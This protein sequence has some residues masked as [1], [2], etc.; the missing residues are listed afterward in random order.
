MRE[1]SELF[2]KKLY[3]P[4]IV[5]EGFQTGGDEVFAIYQRADGSREE[6]S[7]SNLR[8]ESMALVEKL[9]AMGLKKG[10]R[11]ALV[12]AMKPWWYSIYHAA[13]TAGYI[14]VCIDPGA[15]MNQIQSMVQ[16]TECRCVF[17]G[18]DNFRLPRGLEGRIPVMDITPGFPLRG[19]CDRVDILLG[20]AAPMDER[21][22]FVI[23][24]SGTTG[25]RRKG[26]LLP[27]SSVA[28]ALEWNGSADSGIYKDI[29][30][31]TMH[32][33][34]LMLFPP[35][36]IA[37]LMAATLDI[38][39]NTQVIMLEKLTPQVLAGVLQEL[40]PDNV[41]TVP[42]MLTVLMKKIRATL[43]ESPLKNAYVKAA[44][45][46]SGFLRRKFGWKLGFHLL[47][48]VNRAALGGELRSFMIGAS[49]CDAE[50]MRF[51]LDMGIDVPLAYGLSELGAPLAVT[52]KG[53]YLNS[54]GP[55]NH[56]GEGM[57]IRI[58]NPDEQGRGEVEILSPFRMISY[59]REEDMEGCFTEDGYFKT[60]DLGYYNEENCLV[61]C[62][63]AKE[64]IVLR[65]GEK[66]L[67]EEIEAQYKNIPDLAELA[68]FKVPGSGGCDA[69]SLAGVVRKESGL[70]DE[71]I[72]LHI[73]ER[74]A[75]LP[76]MYRPQEV[77]MLRELPL[78][79][80]R[81]VQ[82]FRLTEM[83]EKG[84]NAPVTEASLRAVAEEGLAGELR[85]LLVQVGGPQ[86]KEVELT[87]GLLLDL[88]SLQ[89]I[90]LSVAVQEKFGIDLFQLPTPPETFGALLQAVSAFDEI[91]HTD[92]HELD[93]SRYPEPVSAV[94][95]VVV[96]P[97]VQAIRGA[98]NVH[99]VGTENIPT[100]GNFLICSNHITTLDPVWI[101]ACMPTRY[102]KNT[103][104]VGKSS[105]L[106]SRFLKDL[107]R[108]HN[109]IPVDRTGNSLATL[110]RC[111][112]LLD[113]GWNVEIFPEGTN[114]ENAKEL[115]SFKEGPARLAI[116]AGK[117]VLPVHIKGL[118]HVE[119]HH[120]LP[121]LGSRIEV[122]FGAPISPEGM[123]PA[124]FT[125][126]LRD[127]IQ[128]L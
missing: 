31:Y 33:R 84:L 78:S 10:D 111:K 5:E 102:R 103:A 66:L 58:V 19:E 59:L 108:T 119:T 48:S 117:P 97:L 74:A 36:H 38:Y 92:K 112:E 98:W 75:S 104:I 64:A 77:Y 120:F 67:P 73:L 13:L 118:K 46:L 3:L 80:T 11:I 96:A 9:E 53:Y 27:G 100:E 114:F 60:G 105:L 71:V 22:T 56:H 29:P 24:S 49:P 116:A 16:E 86:W 42:G 18:V 91:E 90:E 39:A 15:P 8:A 122:V 109:F 44:M 85:E 69:F 106:E 70:P 63:R 62:G 34:D 76:A 110:E 28:D 61:I 107:V 113:E 4:A 45:G 43:A 57:D 7:Y 55:V 21:G 88:D 1:N 95:R 25:E 50:T 124:A 82:R 93:L 40:K 123:E 83:A 2:G 35:Y 101:G 26:V 127:T 23:F 115:M 14:M 99:A 32:K 65:N 6:Y 30:A 87:E 17:L 68:A 72:R 89:A 20:S 94:A 12:T 51:F 121:P 128:N 41:C 47:R 52:G 79:A 126:L 81:K 54:T 37:G 125:S